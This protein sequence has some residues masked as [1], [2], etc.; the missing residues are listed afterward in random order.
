MAAT[1][2]SQMRQRQ[3]TAHESFSGTR[4]IPFVALPRCNPPSQLRCWFAAGGRTAR[5]EAE[6]AIP[7]LAWRC[8]SRKQSTK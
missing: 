8:I 1:Q 7:L 4:H 6:R 2:P 5:D 3:L